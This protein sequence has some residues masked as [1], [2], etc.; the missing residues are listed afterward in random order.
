MA[1]LVKRVLILGI[2]WGFVLLGIIGLFLP[3]LQGILFL[4]VGLAVLSMESRTARAILVKLRRRFP[5]L[6]QKMDEAEKRA[7]GMFSRFKSRFDR[8]KGPM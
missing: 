7:R 8:R 5:K 6:A 1:V 3:I 2:G 4:L